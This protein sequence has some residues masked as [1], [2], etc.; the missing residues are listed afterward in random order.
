[1]RVTGADA[2]WKMSMR[3]L[4]NKNSCLRALAVAVCA[5]GVSALAPAAAAAAGAVDVEV[6]WHDGQPAARGIFLSSGG[7]PY[8]PQGPGVDRYTGPVGATYEL[9]YGT[10]TDWSPS[11]ACP[12]QPE[13]AKVSITIPA[14]GVERV[15]VVMPLQIKEM[16]APA[17]DAE[18]LRF[19]ELLNAERA[20]LGRG[21]MAPVDRLAAVADGQ[22]TLVDI[23][24]YRTH[25]G[26]NCET[27]T[28][29]ADELGVVIND[30]EDDRLTENLSVSRWSKAACG[31]TWMNA[32]DSIA[33]FQNS[34]GHWH[35][36]TAA[37]Y[38]QVG[39][40]RVNG[41]WAVVS[42]HGATVQGD[43]TVRPRISASAETQRPDC[44]DN[45]GFLDGGSAEDEPL[46]LTQ[47]AAVVTAG[48][49]L[50]LTGSGATAGQRVTLT[51]TPLRGGAGRTLTTIADSDGR[52]VTTV[53]LTR[54]VRVVAASAGEQNTMTVRVRAAFAKLSAK[55]RGN[56]VVVRGTL[57][58]GVRGAVVKVGG[59]RAV[60]KRKGSFTVRVGGVRRG[61]RVAVK[62]TG[63]RDVFAAASRSLMVR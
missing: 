62:V 42:A 54:S 43:Y 50:R 9:T 31:W 12:T 10:T 4:R 35:S 34:S 25:M 41:V 53:T 22:A 60:T 8:T 48:R 55:R 3:S 2:V 13:T 20:K 58:P 61:A 57:V 39:V 40:A 45:G 18:E 44:D 29:R 15:R 59:K 7:A 26:W 47:P 11:H 28:P 33:G 36:L 38:S 23:Q 14:E 30:G 52:F 27:V 63:Q 19:I 21:P 24:P 5:L 6:V 56:V 46:I 16:T 17:H 49:S 32:A 1:M 37:G 51:V